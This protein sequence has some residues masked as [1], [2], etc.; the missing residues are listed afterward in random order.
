MHKPEVLKGKV[1]ESLKALE[2]DSVDIFYLHV[3]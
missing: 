2:T 3:R 1:E